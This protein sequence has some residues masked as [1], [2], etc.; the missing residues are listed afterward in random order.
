MVDKRMVGNAGQANAGQANAGQ[1][2]GGHGIRL[3]TMRLSLKIRHCDK[4]EVGVRGLGLSCGPR[5]SR[6]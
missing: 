6:N 3:S 2:H 1:A 5:A 4:V